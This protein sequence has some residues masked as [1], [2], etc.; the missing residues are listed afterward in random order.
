M[1]LMNVLRR[2]FMRGV[3]EGAVQ[4][5]SV[6]VFDTSAR[7]NVER[8]QDYGFA[9]NPGDGQGLVI[10]VGGHTVVLRLDRIDGRPQ[11]KAAEVAVWH[12]DGHKVLL[13]DNGKVRI[14]CTTFEVLAKDGVH[15]E[16]PTLETSE[17]FLAK[18]A[19]IT[20]G[21][22]IA[23]RDFLGHQHDNVERGDEQSG[24]VI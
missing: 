8:W 7:E 14:E 6:N 17:M 5:V 2:A 20:E 19:Q 1:N 13:T 11:L 16:T 9:G 15:I 23:D 4:E 22:Q 21:A 18:T 24:G 10:E 12:R 3:T